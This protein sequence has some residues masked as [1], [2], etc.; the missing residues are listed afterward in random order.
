MKG[1][2]LPIS[3][4]ETPSGVIRKVEEEVTQMSVGKHHKGVGEE[5]MNGKFVRLLQMTEKKDAS[6]KQGMV[7]DEAIG[8]A[9]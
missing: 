7:C 5:S 8:V 2:A 4:D 9:F 1:K 6:G 3:S